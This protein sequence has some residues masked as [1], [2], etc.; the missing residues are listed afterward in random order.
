[1]AIAS[2]KRGLTPYSQA[3]MQ[4]PL[5]VQEEAHFREASGPSPVRKRSIT[6]VMTATGEASA[7]L[8]GATLGQTSTHLPHL[9][10]ASSISPVRSLKAAS[11]LR[12]V[13]SN[14]P[15]VE[16]LNSIIALMPSRH[17]VRGAT[18]QLPSRQFVPKPREC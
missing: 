13:M 8:A 5:S 2:R 11:K 9:M 14:P 17:P 4:W 1:R 12:S 18:I 15:V 3:S 7:M 6:P 16:D 10:Q